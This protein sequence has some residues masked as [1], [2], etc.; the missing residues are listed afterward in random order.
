[1]DTQWGGPEDVDEAGA[2]TGTV[3]GIVAPSGAVIIDFEAFVQTLTD[4]IEAF[5]DDVG[6]EFESEDLADSIARA[7]EQTA[8]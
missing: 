7:I 2:S 6:D 3:G 8:G 1:M 4:R 5:R